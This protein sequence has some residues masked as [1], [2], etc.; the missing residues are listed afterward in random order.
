M[1]VTIEETKLYLKVDG[2]EEDTL[3]TS[4]ISSAEE[5]CEGVLRFKL[6][7]FDSVPETVKQAVMFATAQFYE[8]RESIDTKVLIETLKRMLFAYRM[9]GW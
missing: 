8:L 3:I 2:D 9:E 4:F 5:L 7:E 6:S 1:I